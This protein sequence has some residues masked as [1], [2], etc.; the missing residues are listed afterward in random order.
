MFQSLLSWIGFKD[1]LT[2]SGSLLRICVS[3]LVVV[4]W[5]QRQET[6]ALIKA[7]L[8]GFNPCCR[9]LG[10]K[11]RHR[12]AAAHARR[13][14]NPCCRGLGSKT[15]SAAAGDRGQ[16]LFQSLLSWIGFK[17]KAK[18]VR[19]CS[20]DEVSILVVVDWVQRPELCLLRKLCQLP[21]SI[22]VVVDWVQR[23]VSSVSLAS[24]TVV[25]QSLLSWIGFKDAIFGM[26]DHV[27]LLFQSLLSWIGFKDRKTVRRDPGPNQVSILVVVDWVQRPGV[28]N[29]RPCCFSGFNPC[30]RGLGSK[31]FYSSTDSFSVV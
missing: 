31:T 22:L 24:L 15:N 4:D 17:D 26:L 14:F 5:V 8:Q 16:A 23:P 1:C 7:T 12:A 25:F 6:E 18:A 11:T 28:R 27:N 19:P 13:C 21:V 2:T 30:C 29:L 10:S 20:V 9:G 3:I